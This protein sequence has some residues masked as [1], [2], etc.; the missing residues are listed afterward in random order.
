MALISP[1]RGVYYNPDVFSDIGDL[2]APPYDVVDK[3]DRERFLKENPRNIF[4]LEL[5]SKEQCAQP[6]KDRYQCAAKLLEKWLYER[7][8][9]Q[10][11]APTIYLYDIEYQYGGIT[12]IRRGF[13]SLV[14]ADDWQERTV[15]P[16]ERTFA[17]VTEDRFLLRKATK[18][19]FSQIFMIYRHNRYVSEVL[20]S[21]KSDKLFQVN[22]V[23]GTLHTLRRITDSEQLHELERQFRSMELYI[24]DGH[25]RY[26]TAIRYRKEMEARYGLGP[27]AP[28]NFTMAYLV[29]AQDPG[30]VVLPT[31]RL[32]ELPKGLSIDD[33]KKRLSKFFHIRPFDISDA[34]GIV[35]QAGAFED[36]TASTCPQ[37][38]SVMLGADR[39]TFVLCPKDKARQMLLERVGHKE[40][41]D[42][43]VVVLEELVFKAALCLDPDILEAGRDIHFIADS[44]RALEALGPGQM[45]FFMHPTKV[46]Q[47]LAA[48]DAGLC[49]PHKSTFFYPKILTGMLISKE[50]F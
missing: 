46:E 43:D 15:L 21:A 39:Q 14:R 50:D 13:I 36:I 37:G 44:Q 26:T 29:D 47:V 8:L 28:Y 23:N 25:H 31:H 24:A 12:R 48:A 19:Q 49:M 18:A 1:F 42:L 41:A 9:V 6:V 10:D 45:L 16:H 3:R 20:S 4:A 38:I 32:L 33:V 2:I 11:E 27:T 7:I 22:D 34:S 30:L 5:P 40:L 17:K 35:E